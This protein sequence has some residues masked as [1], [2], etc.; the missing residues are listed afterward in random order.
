M[1][2][3]FTARA[4]LRLAALFVAAFAAPAFAQDAPVGFRSPSNNI[5]CQFVGG[6]QGSEGNSVIRCEIMQIANRAPPRPRDCDLDWGQAFEIAGKAA[7][8]AR[9]CHGDTVM[10]GRLP[11][12]PYGETWQR[13]GLICTSK[14]GGVSCVNAKGHG[15]DLSRSVQRVF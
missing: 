6:D 2:G 13:R 11:V 4:M 8:G 12:L 5:H 1:S 9:I 3:L 15:F 10:E 14:P 7:A